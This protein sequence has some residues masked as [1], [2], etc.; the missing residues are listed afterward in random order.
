VHIT[1]KARASRPGLLALALVTACTMQA[2]LEAHD[3]GLSTIELVVRGAYVDATLS[4]AA[5]DAE[6]L[7]GLADSVRVWS[8]GVALKGS[9]LR[10]VRD[11]NGEVRTTLRFAGRRAGQLQVRSEV[12][13][14]LGLGHRQLVSIR[15]ADRVVLARR[16]IDASANAVS[17]QVGA[18]AGG[19]AAVTRVQLAGLL[20]FVL[21]T[22][23]WLC[24]RVYPALLSR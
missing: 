7:Q 4:L 8:G 21:A 19:E 14:R 5:S 11:S 9:L 6:M 3:P 24:A 20:A 22:S 15:N 12:P 16:V 10:S 13:A 18:D 2:P 23:C 1:R 17:V